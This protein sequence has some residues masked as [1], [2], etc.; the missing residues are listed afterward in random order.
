MQTIAKRLLPKCREG[1]TLYQQP[2]F[3][4]KRPYFCKRDPIS[5]KEPLFLQKRPIFR[6][7]VPCSGGSFAKRCLQKE[8]LSSKDAFAFEKVSQSSKL[9]RCHS[10]HI[11]TGC[12]S[13]LQVSCRGKCREG[14]MQ[15]GILCCSVLQCVAVCFSLLQDACK[16][17]EGSCV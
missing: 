15:R 13:V 12:C 3:P 7:I 9:Q 8:S 5:A 2:L 4:Q 10:H 1:S 16:C 6:K 11:N 17:R 14:K